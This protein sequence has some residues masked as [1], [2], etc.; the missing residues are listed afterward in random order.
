[1]RNVRIRPAARGDLTIL[2]DIERASGQQY[3]TYGLDHVADDEPAPVHVLAR[4]A[5]DGRAWV[6]DDES[7]R[8]IGYILVDVIDGGA[9]PFT[10]WTPISEWSWASICR[11]DFKERRAA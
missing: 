3:R 7:G 6:A 4:Y 8:P 1:M 10:A 5:D 11:G 9:Q 2:R